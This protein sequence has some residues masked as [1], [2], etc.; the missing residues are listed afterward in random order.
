MEDG[1]FEEAAT[2]LRQCITVK[3]AYS[4]AYYAL[5]QS[6]KTLHQLD[7]CRDGLCHGHRRLNEERRCH[8]D[9]ESGSAE[10][11][12]LEQLI[13]RVVLALT[14]RCASGRILINIRTRGCP[15][16]WMLRST[17][18]HWPIS[19]R[20]LTGIGTTSQ[21]EIKTALTSGQFGEQ[22][23]QGPGQGFQIEPDGF[24]S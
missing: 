13:E 21:K 22:E 17:S 8:G 12:P 16:W 4:A 18:P 5:A 1:N 3:P 15:R 14:E 20:P 10:S 11:L 19:Y 7:E 6:L 24:R 2:A 23:R 9:E